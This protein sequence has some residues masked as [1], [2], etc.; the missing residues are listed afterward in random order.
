MI[1]SVD[2]N[3]NDPVPLSGQHHRALPIDSDGNTFDA[4]GAAVPYVLRFFSGMGVGDL[5]SQR[6]GAWVKVR[7]LTVKITTTPADS[8]NKLRF[9]IV[10]DRQPV[11]TALSANPTSILDLLQGNSPD[12]WE[13]YY[14]LSHV[15]KTSRFKVLKSWT[16]STQPQAAGAVYKPIHRKTVTIKAPYRIQYGPLATDTIP[17]NQAVYMFCFSDSNVGVGATHPTIAVYSRFRFKD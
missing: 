5:P 13:K 3:P 17:Y 10:L 9:F 11:T 8:Y 4:T 7:S 2:A 1:Q 6:E 12:L 14:N 15:G 16:V